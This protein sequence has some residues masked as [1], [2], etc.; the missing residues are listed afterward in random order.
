MEI[1][2][3]V[4]SYNGFD[5]DFGIFGGGIADLGYMGGFDGF[6]SSIGMNADTFA[7]D[8]NG[9]GRYNDG[10]SSSYTNMGMLS[11]QQQTTLQGLAPTVLGPGES[12]SNDYLAWQDGQGDTWLAS[13][14]VYGSDGRPLADNGVN[15]SQF[16][17][18]TVTPTVDELQASLGEGN[19]HPTAGD[20]LGAGLVGYTA[21]TDGMIERQGIR[22][23]TA[24]GVR[25][26]MPALVSDLPAGIGGFIGLADTY[27]AYASGNDRE[28]FR[29]GVGTLGAI[30]GAEAGMAAGALVPPPFD[31]VTVPVGGIIGAALGTWGGRNA[32]EHIYDEMSHDGSPSP[33]NRPVEP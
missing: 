4:C 17:T 22:S 32:G 13:N 8:S 14:P 6:G 25:Y 29:S 27:A 24:Y 1:A 26:G 31:L 30:G 11:P 19:N 33:S 21:V 12:S 7:Y 10:F 9:F 16:P 5:D 23:A 20:Y 3:N 2:W 28:A 15:V 18:T